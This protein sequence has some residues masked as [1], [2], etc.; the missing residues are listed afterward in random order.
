MPRLRYTLY[1]SQGFLR[2]QICRGSSPPVVWLRGSSCW[3]TVLSSGPWQSRGLGN[4]PLWHGV[5]LEIHRQDARPSIVAILRGIIF[6][7]TSASRNGG[8]KGHEANWRSSRRSLPRLVRCFTF[9]I[10]ETSWTDPLCLR[11]SR[12]I[13]DSESRIALPETSR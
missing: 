12:Q 13:L 6:L 3:D 7:R 1:R 2:G 11:A 10:S 5:P 4:H 8:R 9:H